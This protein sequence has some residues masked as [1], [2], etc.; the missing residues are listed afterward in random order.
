MSHSPTIACHGIMKRAVHLSARTR[1][2]V[3]QLLCS[4]RFTWKNRGVNCSHEV[5]FASSE[6]STFPSFFKG[7]GVFPAI[8]QFSPT[9]ATPVGGSAPK[10]SS[11]HHQR[12]NWTVIRW[13]RRSAD[14]ES[15]VKSLVSQSIAHPAFA[16]NARKDVAPMGQIPIQCSTRH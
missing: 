12:S 2:F 13:L 11:V 5:E 16:F 6:R 9:L 1:T 3:Y 7:E 15:K 4:C 10:H 14:P 8:P